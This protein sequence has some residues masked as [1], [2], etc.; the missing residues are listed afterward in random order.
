[1]LLKEK[2]MVHCP[3]SFDWVDGSE[4]A[5]ILCCRCQISGCL[6]AIHL[7][8]KKYDNSLTNTLICRIIVNIL[9]L[10]VIL[11]CTHLYHTSFR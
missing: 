8:H 9:N 4:T 5:P 7:I 11:L 3:T 2:N 6:E 10:Y 1:M